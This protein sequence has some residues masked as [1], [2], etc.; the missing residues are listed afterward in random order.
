MVSMIEAENHT[1]MANIE[2]Y[3]VRN[4]HKNIKNII[5]S[6]LIGS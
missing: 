4:L 1:K 3:I 6:W 2:T 5:E